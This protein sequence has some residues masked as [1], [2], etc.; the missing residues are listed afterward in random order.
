MN[1]PTFIIGGAMKAGTTSLHYY[2]QAHPQVFIPE[3]PQEL[4][5]FDMDKNFEKGLDWYLN[6]FSPATPQHKAIGQTSPV[7]IYDPKVPPRIAQALPEVKLIFILRNPVDRAYSHYWHSIKMGSE[8]LSFEQALE[9]EQERIAPG[10]KP[11]IA[12]SYVDR[13]WYADQLERYSKH[14]SRD[15]MLILLSENMKKDPS[16]VIDQCCKFLGVEPRGA[17][18]LENL[19]KKYYNAARLPRFRTVQKWIAPYYYRYRK[20]AEFIANLNLKVARY[21]PMSPATRDRLSRRFEEHNQKL[22]RLYDLDLS[23]WHEET[24]YSSPAS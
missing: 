2:L 9:R 8:D 5:F 13:G 22:A 10:G 21:P 11:R 18:I 1:L 19:P 15:N 20:I 4:H 6:H 17:W 7:Y 3:R 12:F 24:N 16:G 14:F 23:P